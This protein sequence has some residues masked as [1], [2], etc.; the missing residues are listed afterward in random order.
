MFE[1][2]VLQL[3]LLKPGSP[4]LMRWNRQDARNAPS[5]QLRRSLCTQ[6]HE[7][8]WRSL[9]LF[10][11]GMGQWEHAAGLLPRLEEAGNNGF[12]ENSRGFLQHEGDLLKAI[13]RGA[14]GS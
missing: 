9:F 12:F 8:C 5:L 3:V 14:M 4:R 11:A 7:S 10:F 6:I 13:A 2:S 1:N